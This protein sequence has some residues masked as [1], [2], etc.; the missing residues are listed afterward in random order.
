M[1]EYYGEARDEDYSAL[2]Q[3][4]QVLKDQRGQLLNH[5]DRLT[6]RYALAHIP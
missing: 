3:E 5:P 4:I 1:D 6:G 2:T